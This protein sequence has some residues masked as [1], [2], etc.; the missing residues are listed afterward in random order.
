MKSVKR[1]NARHD[2]LSKKAFFKSAKV[3]SDIEKNKLF[4]QSEY[5]DRVKARQHH[6]GQVLSKQEKRQIFKDTKKRY[7]SS[8]GFIKNY[9]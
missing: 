3:T 9:L 1:S 8:I 4:A 5:H 2:V 6:K 7:T